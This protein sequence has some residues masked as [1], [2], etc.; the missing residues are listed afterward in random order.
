MRKPL[1]VLAFL[2][3]ATLG[4]GALCA[5]PAWAQGLLSST[6]QAAAATLSNVQ[7]DGLSVNGELVNRSSATVTGVD[8]LVRYNWLWNNE[9]HPGT[10]D[11]GW[12]EIYT[13]NLT[14]PPGTSAPFRLTPT[15][16]APMR[17][18][19]TVLPEPSVSRVTTVTGG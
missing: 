9:Q 16:T 18:D 15:R 14:I 6:Q 19:G 13:I 3:P 11:P 8:L 12:A 4:L 1:P 17:S 7:I 2:V 10:D 5:T